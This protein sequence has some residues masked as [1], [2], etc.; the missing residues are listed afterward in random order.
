VERAVAESIGEPRRRHRVWPWVLGVFL[1]ILLALAG[2]AVGGVALASQALD[3][4]DDLQAAKTQLAAVPELVK[5][6]DT[7]TFD[8]VSAEVLARTSRADKTVQGPLWTFAAFVPFV[9][10]NASAVRDV[11]EA[12]HILVRDALPS[13]FSVLSA[14]Q[15]NKIRFEGGGFNLDSL[16]GIL[17]GLPKVDT[18][19]SAAQKKIDGIDR[20]SLLPVVDSAVGQVLDLISQTAPMVHTATAV[21]PTA[22][23]MLGDEGARTYFVM[24]QNNAEIRATGGNPAAGVLIRVVKGKVSLV[25]QSNSTVLARLGGREFVK[26]PAATLSLYD[27][28]FTK[29]SQNYTRTPNFPTTAALFQ[30]ILRATGQKIDGAISLDPVALSHMLAVAGPVNV[31]GIQLNSENVVSELLNKTYFRYPGD[32]APADAFFAAASAAV[33]NK[34]VAGSWDPLQMVAAMQQSIKEQRVYAWFTRKVDEGLARQ[35]GIDGTMTSD[36]KKTTQVGI[37]LNDSGVG[38]LEYYLSTKVNVDCNVAKRTVTTTLSMTNSVDTNNLTYT[39]HS[40]R[41]GTYGHP[42]TSM[43]L[44]VLSFAPPGAKIT[45]ISPA[46]GDVASLARSGTEDGRRAKSVTVLVDRGQTRTVSYTVTLPKGQ[47][48]PLSVRYSPT[49]TN[50]KVTIA[51]GCQQL[52]GPSAP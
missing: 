9:G 8:K 21:L 47:L 15:S 5:A 40:L 42:G 27:W 34:L 16:H 50:T 28:D 19:F 45:S 11:T 52:T 17:A 49:V 13:T 51:P 20:S 32:Q 2:L 26:L 23:Q 22:L 12:T 24:F 30:G 25:G 4:R 14:L 31:G 29:Y 36:N 43:M 1:I 10:Q 7:K 41:S 46:R 39:I 18:A 6:G 3:V 48:G 44:D 38:K 33:F 37:F 35:L